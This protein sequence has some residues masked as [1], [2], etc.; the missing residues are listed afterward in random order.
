MSAQPCF[1]SRVCDHFKELLRLT[2]LKYQSKGILNDEYEK[3][4]QVPPEP[5]RPDFQHD[6]MVNLKLCQEA[7]KFPF[8]NRYRFAPIALIF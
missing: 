8:K 2:T 3:L 7:C 6:A 4:E 1:S 5:G